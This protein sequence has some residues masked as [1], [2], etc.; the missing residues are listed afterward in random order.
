MY[1][2]LGGL[3][4]MSTWEPHLVSVI[5]PCYNGARFLPE[6]IE[7]V[8][9][10]TYLQFEIIVVDDGSTDNSGEIAVRYPS[11]RYIRQENQGVAAARNRGLRESKGSY[12][13]FLDQDDRMTPNALE[14]G[15]SCLNAHPDCALVFGF[16]KRIEADGSPWLHSSQKPVE[17][18]HRQGVETDYYR[19]LLRGSDIDICPPSTVMFRHVMFESLSGFNASLAPADDY[20]V[21][22]RIARAFPI[23]CHEKVIVEYRM[24]GANQSGSTVRMLRATLQALGA[25]RDYI[26]G[27]KEYEEAYKTGKRYWRN[28]WGN[29]LFCKVI[30]LV[31]AQRLVAA[32]RAIVLLMRY[33]PHLQVF[34]RYAGKFL[35]YHI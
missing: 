27:N 13:V 9:G 6:A 10:Q 24:H 11:V 30:A 12:L 16:C 14:T 18:H 25:Q 34:L 8:L 22:L 21:Y 20:D 1:D 32:L 4:E 19:A 5:I 35:F 33:P 29:I 3:E 28:Y 17:T 15:V 26:K 31:K 23:Y 2:T 7:S